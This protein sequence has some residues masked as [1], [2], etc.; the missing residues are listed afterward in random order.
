MTSKDNKTCITYQLDITI[1]MNTAYEEGYTSKKC[2]GRKGH[3]MLKMLALWSPLGF[4]PKKE[5]NKSSYLDGGS[6][7]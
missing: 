3:E 1:C 4:I 5:L 2:K 7:P 6:L